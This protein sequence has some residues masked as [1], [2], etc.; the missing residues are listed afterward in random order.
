MNR[1]FKLPIIL[2]LIFTLSSCSFVKTNKITEPTSSIKVQEPIKLPTIEETITTLCS[3]EFGGRLVGSNGNELAGNYIKDYFKKLKLSYI[4]EEDYSHRYTQE[5]FSNYGKQPDNTPPII[6][7]INNIVGVIK[8]K[9]SSNAVVISAHYDHIGYQEGK[10]IKGALDNASGVA[11]LLEIAQNLKAKSSEKP[12]NMDIVICSFNAEEFGL[13]GSRAFIKDIKSK[14]NTLY[15]I[16]IDCVGAKKGGKLALKN[17]SKISDKL[18]STMKDSFLKNSIEFSDTSVRGFSD[19]LS[20]EEA[21]IPN[22]FIVQEG[23]ENLVHSPTDTP[24][25]LDFNEIKKLSNA[26]CDFIETNNGVTF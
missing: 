7:S 3:D 26:I 16:N 5:V 24:E 10:I 13:K 1:L 19:H 23:I 11:T 14:Y 9:S 21:K 12:F 4:Y 2:L 8:G 22:I 17:K 25:I 6:K 20:F 15:N 18:Y